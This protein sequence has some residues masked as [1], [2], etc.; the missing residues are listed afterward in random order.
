[1]TIEA[2][3]R[4]A[5]P[6]AK[7]FSALADFEGAVKWMPGLES[8]KVVSSGVTGLGT[9]FH[10]ERRVMKNR[11]DP[12]DVSV[13]KYA[14]PTTLAL[15][16]KRNGKPT[17]IVTWTAKPDGTGTLLHCGM[18]LKMPAIIAFIWGGM[19][20]K[21]IAGDIAGLKKFVEGTS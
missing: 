1:M 9:Q 13:V 11:V 3:G 5:A 7:V 2:Q 15:D 14:P 18:E 12:V 16:V 10:Q 17:A 4:I 6:P 8:S 20:R 21:Q 19:I